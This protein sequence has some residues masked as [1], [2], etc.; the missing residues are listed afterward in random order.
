MNDIEQ[1]QLLVFVA[2]GVPLG[3]GMTWLGTIGRNFI[4]DLIGME[5]DPLF[6][7]V[8]AFV[9]LAILARRTIWRNNVQ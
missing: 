4:S 6:F 7:A 9:V 8:L 2:I 1:R 5:I 3:L